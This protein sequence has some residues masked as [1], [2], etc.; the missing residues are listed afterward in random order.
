M[1]CS[2][3]GLGLSAPLDASRNNLVRALAKDVT[4]PIA[5]L[6]RLR[7]SLE[8]T[9]TDAEVPTRIEQTKSICFGIPEQLRRLN[10]SWRPARRTSLTSR[11]GSK[12]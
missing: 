3:R 12:K 2:F 9:T 7:D 10:L 1:S 8:S 5:N 6:K 4:E 11:K